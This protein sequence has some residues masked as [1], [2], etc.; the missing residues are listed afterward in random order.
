MLGVGPR[1]TRKGIRGDENEEDERDGCQYGCKVFVGI[2]MN[3][4]IQFGKGMVYFNKGNH[5]AAERQFNDLLNTNP[6]FCDAYVQLGLINKS[7]EKKDIAELLFRKAVSHDPTN[8]N[9]QVQLG[10]LFAEGGR[11]D[12][13]V[14]CFSKVVQL[15]PICTDALL[16][17]AN[18]HIRQNNVEDAILVLDRIHDI[19]PIAPEK[20]I[21]LLSSLIESKQFE[22]TIKILNLCNMLKPSVRENSL[23]DHLIF[24]GSFEITADFAEKLIEEWKSCKDHPAMGLSMMLAKRLLGEKQWKSDWKSYLHGIPLANS[25][26][27]KILTVFSRWGALEEALELVREYHRHRTNATDNLVFDILFRSGRF[28]DALTMSP[29]IKN[30]PYICAVILRNVGKICEGRNELST[31]RSTMPPNEYSY[32]VAHMDFYDISAKSMTLGTDTADNFSPNQR[33]MLDAYAAEMNADNKILLELFDAWEPKHMP[34]AIISPFLSAALIR[35]GR[36]DE[37]NTVLCETLRDLPLNRIAEPLLRQELI[38]KPLPVNFSADLKLCR[39]WVSSI[40][41]SASQSLPAQY[42]IW[43]LYKPHFPHKA[44]LKLANESLNEALS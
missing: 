33:M 1:P 38:D 10:I 30:K 19:N 22:L 9:A 42:S 21:P 3:D 15:N 29:T 25:G 43:R 11:Y 12:A 27:D 16:N 8:E 14:D 35:E 32:Q 18:A 41:Y 20:T 26:L 4:W 5:E 34:A 13:A 7:F 24:L 17:L 44:I 2:K 23:I 40:F 37:G 39:K 36:Q 28:H 31:Y 6:D